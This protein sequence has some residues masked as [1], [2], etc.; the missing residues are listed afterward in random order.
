MIALAA[1]SHL[2]P[3]T[4]LQPVEAPHLYPLRRESAVGSF[5]RPVFL[6]SYH[7]LRKLLNRYF[8]L[9]LLLPAS[10]AKKPRSL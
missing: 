5:T 4:W 9:H 2:T 3:P 1:A 7:T 8:V 10:L 6:E